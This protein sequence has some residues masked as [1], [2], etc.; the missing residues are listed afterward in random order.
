MN[1]LNEF[2][3]TSTIHGLAYISTAPSKLSKV[4]WMLV[5]IFGFSTAFY[6]I[7]DSYTAWEA[8]PIAT[9]ISTHPISEL[10]FPTITVC[11]PE[12]SN[13]ALNYDLVRAQNITLS[14]KDRG[15]LV[16]M[17]TQI[18]IDK[19]SE[20]FVH[21]GR[22]L[23]SEENI[24]DM[25]ESTPILTYPMANN[26]HNHNE[27]SYDIWTSKLNGSY[28]T[29]GF[30]RRYACNETI[31]EVHLVLELPLVVLNKAGDEAVLDIQVKTQDKY[32]WMIQYREGQKYYKA[33]VSNSKSWSSAQNF[34]IEKGGDLAIVKN[35]LDRKEI[36]AASFTKKSWIGGTDRELE[37]VWV[38]LD[39]TP[40]AENKCSS[41]DPE[42]GDFSEMCHDWAK[43]NPEGGE[44]ENCLSFQGSV[45]YSDS[46]SD[47]L[48]FACQFNPSP[49]NADFHKTLRLGRLDFSTIELWLAK[50][51]TAIEESCDS[52]TLWPGFSFSWNT[53]LSKNED[54]SKPFDVSKVA[55]K[56]YKDKKHNRVYKIDK[57]VAFA[58]RMV[59]YRIVRSAKQYN[60]TNI[61]I[62]DMVKI[63]KRKAIQKKMFSCEANYVKPDFFSDIFS[64]LQRQLPSDRPKVPH[65]E[66]KDDLFLSF[67]I[68]S[69]LTFC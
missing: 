5:V 61:E 54:S 12:G 44:M 47:K 16:N 57:Y 20:E 67:D 1:L 4:F 2:L 18:L 11:P 58:A 10:D 17:T 69:Y 33:H 24:I 53:K 50:N 52:S 6:L 46:C 34:C 45:S 7:N 59:R 21:V 48:P 66:T 27:P 51:A 39:G 63:W 22:S 3:E 43:T 35:I 32:G 36:N 26:D 28:E 14:E 9:S 60:M 13:T 8:S 56:M 23:L 30:G 25:F 38:W 55:A 68:F 31:T 42:K 49:L 41:I 29:P 19:P 40:L 64:G 37:G 62:W 15:T 65:E